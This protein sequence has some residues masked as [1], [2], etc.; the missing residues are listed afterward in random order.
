[1]PA[2]NLPPPP[3]GA[4]GVPGDSGSYA[5]P[6]HGPVD[7]FYPQPQYPHGGHFPRQ[8][9]FNVSLPDLSPG[10]SQG[11]IVYPRSPMSAST[12][13]QQEGFKPPL[14]P[15]QSY[16]GLNR[17]PSFHSPV[18]AVDMSPVPANHIS[19][20]LLS[21]TR[22]YPRAVS[23]DSNVTELE[24]E[25]RAAT[26][27][28]VTATMPVATPRFEMY[29]FVGR[30]DR[31]PSPSPQE[32]VRGSSFGQG[33]TPSPAPRPMSQPVA[34]DHFPTSALRSPFEDPPSRQASGSQ[35]SHHP[36]PKPMEILAQ[37]PTFSK[38]IDRDPKPQA[39]AYEVSPPTSPELCGVDS[40]EPSHSPG[41]STL[42]SY[43]SSP[44]PVAFRGVQEC[45]PGERRGG[46]V[47]KSEE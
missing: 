12:T 38:K 4:P 47:S 39:A 11:S 19:P 37:S 23:Y 17:A 28:T 24:P 20:A 35:A 18:A 34:A 3:P 21:A 9:S 40:E 43:P 8:Y 2:Y 15:T 25:R 46:A 16:P 36:Y 41:P 42:P 45:E 7:Y 22:Q 5:V 31:H 6:F 33:V 30:V 44:L 32:S 13:D 29:N 1:M 27:A 10:F 26:A 14:V